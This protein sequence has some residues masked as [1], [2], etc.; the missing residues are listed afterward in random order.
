MTPGNELEARQWAEEL[1]RTLAVQ[2]ITRGGRP[3]LERYFV[4]GWHPARRRPGPAVFLHHFVDSDASD[5]IHSHPWRWSMSVILAGGYIEHR[6]TAAG[7]IARS[8]RAGEV[9]VLE[10]ADK[11]RIELLGGDCWSIFLAGE[12]QQPWRFEAV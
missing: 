3:Y 2:H 6:W 5:E 12:Y 11:H 10:A 1:A 4:G 8:F 9:N 7:M